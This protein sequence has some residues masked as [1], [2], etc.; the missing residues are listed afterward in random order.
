MAGMADV[1]R[2]LIAGVNIIALLMLGLIMQIGGAY[3]VNVAVAVLGQ[4][5]GAAAA[6]A[7]EYSGYMNYIRSFDPRQ[8]GHAVF[9]A[10]LVEEL[11]FRLIFLRAGK[12]ILPFWAANLVQAILFGIYHGTSFQR[13]YGFVMGL[14][15]GC[16]FYYCPLIYRS[17]N[18]AEG[19]GKLLDFPN[20]LMGVAFSIILH[21]TINAAGLF[22]APLFPADIAIGVQAAIGICLMGTAVAVCIRLWRM[23][24]LHD[25][26][27]TDTTV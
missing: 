10:P 9:V 13:V 23:S 8:I 16:V 22:V 1:K 20:S 5:A 7:N 12:M 17:C 19:K 2:Y 11:V 24:R 21:M 14:I 4:S 6:A 25:D 15:I 26:P 27:V 18:L 3:L